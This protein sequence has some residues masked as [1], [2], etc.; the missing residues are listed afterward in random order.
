MSF[1]LLY[2]REIKILWLITKKS[3]LD[4]NTQEKYKI[5]VATA[6]LKKCSSLL[7]KVYIRLK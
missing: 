4:Q 7:Q 5:C 2:I 1:L 3:I 6:Q